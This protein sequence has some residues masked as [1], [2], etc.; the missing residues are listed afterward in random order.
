MCR[1]GAEFLQDVTDLVGAVKKEFATRTR[2]WQEG[3]W[4][5]IHSHNMWY[6][7]VERAGQ[8]N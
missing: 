1:G 4:G 2:S 7:S 3:P 6:R 5:L 8:L